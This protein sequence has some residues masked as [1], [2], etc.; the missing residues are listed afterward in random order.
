MN[1]P[2][3]ILNQ[4]IINF[5]QEITFEISSAK[6]RPFVQS[7]MTCTTRV[8]DVFPQDVMIPT[9]LHNKLYCAYW[10]PNDVHCIGRDGISMNHD[11]IIKR[12]QFPRYWPFVKAMHRSQRPVT[13]SFDIFSDLRKRLS[14][15][16]IRRWFD[17]P[18]RSLWRH[19]NVYWPNEPSSFWISPGNRWSL[20]GNI[21]FVNCYNHS[22]DDVMTRKRCPH[23]WPFVRGIYR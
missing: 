20:I 16:S 8:G 9:A 11:D 23:Y 14:K 7:L 2:N 19:C 10:C 5:I 6:C 12:K 4:M 3:W 22:Y 1:K 15:R 17:T 18:S 21:D 13:L